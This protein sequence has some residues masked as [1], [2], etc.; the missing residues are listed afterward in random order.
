MK[1]IL[2]IEDDKQLASTLKE[3]FVHMK[4]DVISL[5]DANSV[6]EKINKNK[7]DLIISDYYLPGLSGLEIME[8]IRKESDTPDIPV[9]FLSGSDDEKIKANCL[10]NGAKSFITKPFQLKE[11]ISV[12]NNLLEENC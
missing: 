11:L 6:I 7:P 12:V 1:K 8:C 2:I 5:S 4:F 3:V 9:I 10:E